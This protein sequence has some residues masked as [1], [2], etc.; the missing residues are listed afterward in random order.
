MARSFD[1]AL[2]A[3]SDST[4]TMMEAAIECANL[5]IR[6]FAEHG[7]LSNA[8][9]FVD[10]MPKNYNR[11]SA[12]LAWLVNFAPV[13]MEAGKLKKDSVRA[14]NFEIDLDAAEAVAFYDFKPQAEIVNF[15]VDDVEKA[16]AAIVRKFSN[17]EKAKP[18]NDKAK[19]KLAAVAKLAKIEIPAAA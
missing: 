10:A 11:K 18:L 19:A 3:F 8:Q 15:D 2:K 5:S 12:F 4:K 9:R 17:P 14:A 7:D 6:Q 16:L 13:K 1:D